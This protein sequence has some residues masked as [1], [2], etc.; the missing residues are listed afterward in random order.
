MGKELHVSTWKSTYSSAVM[1]HS[2]SVSS[3]KSILNFSSTLSCSS[4]FVCSLIPHYAKQFLMVL[5]LTSFQASATH[6]IAWRMSMPLT[7]Y[8]AN[9]SSFICITH[10]RVNFFRYFV[11]K[12][13]MIP[14]SSDCKGDIVFFRRKT[15]FI[16]LYMSINEIGWT[17]AL[18]KNKIT[19]L[20]L[21]HFKL[22]GIQDL[23][24]NFLLNPRFG[25]IKIRNF[26]KLIGHT[27]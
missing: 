11:L 9:K 4:S 8:E 19:F 17:V 18:S 27:S 22:K 10:E 6:V 7:V 25:I 24:L 23:L 13:W 15:I 16:L 2:Q 3:M 14:V 12:L 20:L 21:S 26:S 5:S 1:S